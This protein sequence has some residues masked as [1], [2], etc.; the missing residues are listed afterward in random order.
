MNELK[1][2]LLNPVDINV[3]KGEIAFFFHFIAMYSKSVCIWNIWLIF[4]TLVK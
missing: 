4:H 1:E 2:E 3:E